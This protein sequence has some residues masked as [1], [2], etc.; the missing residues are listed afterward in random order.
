MNIDKAG[1]QT[2]AFWRLESKQLDRWAKDGLNYPIRMHMIRGLAAGWI[3]GVAWQ[4]RNQRAKT[5]ETKF[6]WRK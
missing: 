6:E 3:A 5:G 4:K 2:R 1:K